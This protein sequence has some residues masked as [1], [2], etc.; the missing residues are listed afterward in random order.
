[1]ALLAR[2]WTRTRAVVAALAVAGVFSILLLVVS[3]GLPARGLVTGTA[4]VN[5]LTFGRGLW[6]GVLAF[7]QVGTTQVFNA[8]TDSDGRFT[9]TLSPGRYRVVRD[10]PQTGDCFVPD[11][12]R[13]C[14]VQEFTLTA[15]EHLKAD[16]TFPQFDQ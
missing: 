9:E 3:G 6:H 2:N 7:H 15:G 5:S 1:M 11:P 16:F 14:V 10:P 4:Y 8:S 13:E 12:S